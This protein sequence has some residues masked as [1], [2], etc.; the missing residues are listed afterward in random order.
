[1]SQG[2]GGV[3]RHRKVL[4]YNIQGITKPAILRLA[5][6][7][8]VK[9]ASGLVFEE[10]RGVLKVALTKVIRDAVTLTEHRRA[11]TVSAR[12]IAEALPVKMWSDN[13]KPTFKYEAKS[14]S[15]AGEE[16]K[17]GAAE[18]EKAA[19]KKKSKKSPKGEEKKAPG[20]PKK[21]HRYKAGT[22]AL[23]HI[24]RYQKMSSAL[25][26]RMLP[27]ERLA[28]EIAQDFKNDLRFSSNGLYILQFW[29]ESY[30]VGLFEDTN[31]CAIHRKGVIIM[32]KDIQL[33][34]RIRGERA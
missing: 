1:M 5:H 14:R 33:A 7:G 31:L 30:L 28:R 15:K 25:M 11:K 3:K 17:E 20:G 6:T 19:P 21:P 18:G 22:V 10:T 23:R 27:F 34:R 29:A 32:P 12:D 26:I 24:R 16:K 4:R 9:S 8:G 13:P 2:K